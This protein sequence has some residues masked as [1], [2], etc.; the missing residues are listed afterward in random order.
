MHNFQLTF[1]CLALFTFS[2]SF[3]YH[4]E[5]APHTNPKHDHL[6]RSTRP[7]P[8]T[9]MT[10]D[11]TSTSLMTTDS[12]PSETQSTSD[13]STEE[14]T[15]TSD[16]TESSTGNFSTTTE[17][18]KD[19]ETPNRKTLIFCIFGTAISLVILVALIYCIR[20]HH[21]SYSVKEQCKPFESTVYFNNINK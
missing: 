5:P 1:V 17:I 7:S 14:S 9:T 18:S 10:T 6:L 16:F 4:S 19:N 11:S 8:T 15:E 20:R 13:T 12:T 2:S 21:G 3:G